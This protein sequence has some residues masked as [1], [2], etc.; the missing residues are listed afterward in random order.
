MIISES[1]QQVFCHIPKNGGSSLRHYF[2]A[3][4]SDHR[5]YQG[6]QP[7]AALD[8][9][10]RDLTHITTREAR[11]LFDDD[12]VGAGH[13]ILA[14]IRAPMP[15]VASA[16][17]QYVR[18]FRAED[19]NFADAGTAAGVL[20][21]TSIRA[22]CERADSDHR[23]IFLR[24]QVDF[25]EDVPDAAQD[26]VLLEDLSARFPDLPHE[27]RGGRLPGWL[28]PLSTPAVRRL[29]GMFGR[30][31]KAQLQSALTRPDQDMRETIETALASE[32]GFLEDFYGPDQA[33]YDRLSAQRS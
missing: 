17:A 18:T 19:R 23:C 20:A 7:V 8:G 4:W 10:V 31:L 32:R 11:I 33:L 15:R 26:L 2:R 21:Q 3:T 22:L 16:V 24:R 1:R 6:R 28:K 13:R 9:A 14:V 25:L 29:T 5:Q 30:R 27:N 12:L